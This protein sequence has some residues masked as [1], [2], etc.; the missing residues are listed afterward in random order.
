MHTDIYQYASYLGDNMLKIEKNKMIKKYI[1]P[2]L[3]KIGYP[4]IVCCKTSHGNAWSSLIRE[5]DLKKNFNTG[6]I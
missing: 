5:D 3:S 2:A 6:C 1:N 4:E